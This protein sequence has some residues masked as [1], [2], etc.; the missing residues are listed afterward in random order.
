MSVLLFLQ[1]DWSASPKWISNI[2]G[3][4][5]TMNPEAPC[6]SISYFLSLFSSLFNLYHKVH[7]SL[8]FNQNSRLPASPLL[9]LLWADTVLDVTGDVPPWGQISSPRIHGGHPQTDSTTVHPSNMPLCFLSTLSC[10]PFLSCLPQTSD[11]PIPLSHLL[12]YNP[13]SF[14][15]GNTASITQSDLNLL[16]PSTAA[17]PPPAC[18]L[19]FSPSHPSGLPVPMPQNPS[20]VFLK[21]PT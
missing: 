13:P 19:A 18:S 14:F 21:K 15:T 4:F 3:T 16:L 7:C 6:Q 8:C 17:H 10:T 5:E 20:S 1:E 2:N 11:R 12:A 9:F